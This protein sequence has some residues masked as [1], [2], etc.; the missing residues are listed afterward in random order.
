MGSGGD[1]ASRTVPPLAL[2]GTREE[3]AFVKETVLKKRKENADWAVRNRERKAAKRLRI[4]EENKAVVKRPEEFVAAFRNKERDFLRMRTRLKVRKQPPAEALSS[5]LIF[6]IRIPGSV[7][8]HPHIRKIL[9]KLRLTKVL[10]GVFLKATELTLKRLLV[11]EPFVTYGFPNL[12]NVKEL[13][14]KKGRG[15]LDKEPFPLTSN[16][17]IEKV[18]FHSILIY[19]TKMPQPIISRKKMQQYIYTSGKSGI[20]AL[21]KGNFR[22]TTTVLHNQEKRVQK[23]GIHSGVPQL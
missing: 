16:D 8:L 12:K 20:T 14:Y 22:K 15:F 9:R 5:K 13:I 2:G 3:L 17:L 10:T 23:R 1:E 18:H 7:D 21:A 6:A 19:V 11:V 4:R